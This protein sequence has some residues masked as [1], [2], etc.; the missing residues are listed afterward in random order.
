[1]TDSDLDI[2]G[3]LSFLS[4]LLLY[5]FY[6]F[7]PFLCAAASSTRIC[8]LALARGMG[9]RLKCLPVLVATTIPLP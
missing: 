5:I 4:I 3:P 1:L 8:A 9:M 7:S 2:P 6:T